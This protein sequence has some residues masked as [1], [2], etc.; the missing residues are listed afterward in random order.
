MAMVFTLVSTLKDTAESLISERRGAEQAVKDKE[1]AKAEEEE[2]KKFHGSAVTRQSFL[3]WQANFKEEMEKLERKKQEEKEAEDKRKRV[4]KE[5]KK[6]TGRELWEKGLA[7]K[8][9]EDYDD[10]VESTVQDTAKMKL[11]Q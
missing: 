6:L 2:N 4:S 7:G 11:E 3:E 1:A 8:M 5:E 9:D 10:D